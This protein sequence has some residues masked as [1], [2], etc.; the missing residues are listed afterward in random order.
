M[1]ICGRALLLLI[2]LKEMS[3]VPLQVRGAS[4]DA[5][6][7]NKAILRVISL[8]KKLSMMQGKYA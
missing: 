6:I 3:F 4:K 1:K 2:L 7:C 5:H 8:E